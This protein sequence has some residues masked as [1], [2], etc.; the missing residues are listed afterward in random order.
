M[1]CVPISCFLN[2][3]SMIFRCWSFLS[4]LCMFLVLPREKLFF[5]VDKQLW[6]SW[7][8]FQ[9]FV[10]SVATRYI[11]SPFIKPH[12]YFYH[13]MSIAAIIRLFLKNIQ[14]DKY[15][16]DWLYIGAVNSIIPWFEFKQ[17]H[18]VNFCV[19]IHEFYH[20]ATKVYDESKQERISSFSTS[21][22]SHLITAVIWFG[23]S[24][25]RL[26]LRSTMLVDKSTVVWV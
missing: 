5:A 11:D 24:L 20:T 17:C 8:F 14:L 2:K 3:I 19:N 21:R 9:H 23:S 6:Q 16:L 26:A 4:H 10:T 25:W 12:D 1:I 18:K 13:P 7:K 22:R 15:F